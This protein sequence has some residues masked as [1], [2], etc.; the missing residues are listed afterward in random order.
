MPKVAG[1]AAVTGRNV[2]RQIFISPRLV[3][4]LSM[5]LPIGMPAASVFQDPPQVSITPREKPHSSNPNLRVDVKMILVP[6][7]VM[8][9]AD[10]PVENLQ[11]GRLPGV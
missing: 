11:T 3:A 8:D 7:T 6:I 4:A 9:P 5:L 10:K 1:R 2:F